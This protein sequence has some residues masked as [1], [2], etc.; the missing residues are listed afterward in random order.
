MTPPSR[1]GMYAKVLVAEEKILRPDP[2]NFT[3]T[4]LKL[5]ELMFPA[6]AP[7]AGCPLALHPRSA[8]NSSSATS[9]RTLPISTSL[10]ASASTSAPTAPAAMATFCACNAM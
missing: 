5:Y 6:S 2:R 7:L 10:A 3:P 8:R 1:E 4:T 9:I